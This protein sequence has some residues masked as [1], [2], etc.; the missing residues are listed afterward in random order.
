MSK[1]PLGNRQ[2]ADGQKSG[3]EI[4]HSWWIWRSRNAGDPDAVLANAECRM[5]I[6]FP[7]AISCIVTPAH[8][9]VTTLHLAES[10]LIIVGKASR[11]WAE[12]AKNRGFASAAH[13]SF[14]GGACIQ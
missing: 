14:Q 2:A 9:S 11:L 1:A 8:T 12:T 13:C 4:R 5:P 6:A 3:S 10:G 7:C